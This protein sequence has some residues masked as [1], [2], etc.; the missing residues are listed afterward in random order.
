MTDEF[1]TYGPRYMSMMP[2][3]SFLETTTSAHEA[4]QSALSTVMGVRVTNAPDNV[5]SP[6]ADLLHQVTKT[7]LAN[8]AEAGWELRRTDDR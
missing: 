8:L 6:E 7:L 2:N 4:L 5:L 3:A 1:D